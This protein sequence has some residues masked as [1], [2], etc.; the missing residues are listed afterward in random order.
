MSLKQ[1]HPLWTSCSSNPFEVNKAVC[2]ARLLSGRYRSD[3]SCRYWSRSNK[4]G[5]CVLC[6]DLSTPGTIEHMLVSC[7]ALGDKRELLLSYWKQQAHNCPLLQ[8]L[9]NNMVGAPDDVFVQFLLDPSASP[10]VIAG[11][12]DGFLDLNHI[13]QLTRTFCYGLHRRRLQLSGRFNII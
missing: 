7:P 10:A 8:D 12:Q 1:C 5:F 6:P 11:V 3:W 4:N 13:F 2:Q 9:L